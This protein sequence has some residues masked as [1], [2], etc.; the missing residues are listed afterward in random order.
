MDYLSN[1]KRLISI[2]N[3]ELADKLLHQLSEN[4]NNNP[5]ILNLEG[6]LQIKKNK[7]KKA[8]EKFLKAIK[9]DKE[10]GEAY[11]NLGSLLHNDGEFVE[12]EEYLIKANKLKKNY[13]NAIYI[14]GENYLCLGKYE[15]AISNFL[16]LLDIQPEHNDAFIKLLEAFTFLKEESLNDHELSVI[17]NKLKSID[18]KIN[19]ENKFEDND[20]KLILNKIMKFLSKDLTNHQSTNTQILKRN[21]FH[22]NCGRHHNIFFKKNIL[23]EDC[24]SCFKVQVE[25]KNVIDLI[26]LYLI[27]NKINFKNNNFRKC[28]VEMRENISGNYKGLVYCNNLDEAHDVFSKLQNILT[29]NIDEKIKITIKRGCSEF[30]KRFD[31]YNKVNKDGLMKYNKEWKIIEKNYDKLISGKDKSTQKIFSENNKNINLNDALVILNWIRYANIIKDTSYEKMIKDDFK[32][33]YPLEINMS[34][35]KSKRIKQ[36]LENQLKA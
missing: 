35:Q 34:S 7:H 32:A 6:I 4:E 26:K 36:F 1:I 28:F 22:L 25:L 19:V 12:A 21:N 23:P 20:V 2:N 30:G 15:Q 33:S 10:F 29:N 14:L 3:L 27:F 24:F 16:N 8:K 18:Y 13:I 9:L 5:V 17:N 31:D 11:F